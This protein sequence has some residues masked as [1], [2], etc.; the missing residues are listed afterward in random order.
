ML[1]SSETNER[2]YFVL[3]YNNGQIFQRILLAALIFIN[4]CIPFYLNIGQSH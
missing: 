3:K 2:H 4:I 1:F